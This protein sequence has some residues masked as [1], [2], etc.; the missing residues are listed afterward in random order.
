MPVNMTAVI[1][2][3]CQLVSAMVCSR[4]KNLVGTPTEP[5]LIVDRRIKHVGPAMCWRAVGIMFVRT[6]DVRYKLTQV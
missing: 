6:L 4:K 1:P 3:H 5:R 2:W